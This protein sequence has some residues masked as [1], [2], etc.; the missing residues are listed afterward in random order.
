MKIHLSTILHVILGA[1]L[2][3]VGTILL[4]G[5]FIIDNRLSAIE[6]DIQEL[7]ENNSRMESRIDAQIERFTQNYK[8]VKQRVD[9]FEGGE[10]TDGDTKAL[11]AEVVATQRKY[12]QD[13]WGV[14]VGEFYTEIDYNSFKE[15]D[16]ASAAAKEFGAGEVFAELNAKLATVDD[17]FFESLLAQVIAQYQVTW[18]EAGG[19]SREAQTASGQ[20][21]QKDIA[22]AIAN[23]IQ[24]TRSDTEYSTF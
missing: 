2:S 3:S 23:F 21:A 6:S 15:N 4:I 11:L 13:S 17:Q 5:P 22:A 9:K 24:Q 16:D 18:N 19:I 1:A 10:W 14:N 12:V 8:S 7:A 20:Q